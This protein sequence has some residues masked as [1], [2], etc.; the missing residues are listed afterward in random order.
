MPNEPD[1]EKEKAPYMRDPNMQE[2]MDEIQ[3]ILKKRDIMGVFM[4]ATEERAGWFQHLSPTWSAIMM[5]PQPDGSLG[6]R[7]RCKAADYGGDKE[8]QKK[9]LESTIN[10]LSGILEVSF[11]ILSTLRTLFGK[12]IEGMEVRS[13]THDVRTQPAKFLPD[14]DGPII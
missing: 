10:G 6:V 1:K 8:A 12:A 5:E 13:I 4:I 11:P 7:L 3:A 14:N 9:H 2:A